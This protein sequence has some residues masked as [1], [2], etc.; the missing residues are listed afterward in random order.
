MCAVE[1][2]P[3]ADFLEVEW[4]LDGPELGVLAFSSSNG[5]LVAMLHMR[6]LS[7]WPRLTVECCKAAINLAISECGREFRHDIISLM[8]E[9][10][11]EQAERNWLLTLDENGRRPFFMEAG[12][13]HGFERVI[14]IPMVTNW[15]GS[16]V[17]GKN[18]GR[19]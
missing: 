7:S 12:N 1:K 16:E 3:P 13:F 11:L 10:L 18:H 5:A 17:F 15:C 19:R 8:Y 2:R 6:P 9:H 4:L 14:F